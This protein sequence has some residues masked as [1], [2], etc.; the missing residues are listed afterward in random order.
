MANRFTPKGGQGYRLSGIK[1][2]MIRGLP[3]FW[4][5]SFAALTVLVLSGI[6]DAGP[7]RGRIN[8]QEKLIPDVYAEAAKPDAHRYT[9]REPSPTVKP[10]FRVLSGNP[11]REVCIAAISNGQ[12]PPADKPTLMKV[13]GG[14][15]VPAT[16]A[17]SNGTR[18]SFKNFDPFPHRLYIVGNATWRA[19]TINPNAQR[20]WS[21]PA[22]AG[23]FEF[24]DELFPSLRTFVIVDP[25]VADIAYPGRDGSFELNLSAGDYTLKAFFNGKPVGSPSSV[26]AK[27]GVTVLKDPFNLGSSDGAH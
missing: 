4:T 19:E 14:R 13:T 24:R 3:P 7:V 27:Q 8:G 12:M 21:A 1:T 2:D 10:E 16:I 9:W 5:S 15:T 6:A 22:G 11:S 26:T 23:R 18:L 20:D 25:G 17:V